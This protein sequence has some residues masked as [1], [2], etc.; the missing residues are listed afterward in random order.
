MLPETI[1]AEPKAERFPQWV[2]EGER[3]ASIPRGS[4]TL[5]ELVERWWREAESAG[6]TLSTF[7]SYE[8]ALRRALPNSSGMTMQQP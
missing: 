2:H 7:E 4:L 1:L 5:S 3:K 6:R 8:V